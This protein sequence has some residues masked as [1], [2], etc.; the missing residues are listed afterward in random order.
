MPA[1]STVDASGMIDFAQRLVR[2]PS[3]HDPSRG[4]NEEKVAE[5]VAEQIRAFGWQPTTCSPWW[6]AACRGRR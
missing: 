3:V 6:T 4:L 5:M 2:V 1:S